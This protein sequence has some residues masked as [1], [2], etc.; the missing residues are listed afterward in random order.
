MDDTKKTKA[1]LID[2]LNQLR[3]QIADLQSPDNELHP[4]PPLADHADQYFRV[5]LENMRLIG[6]MLDADGRVTFCN[7]CL[8]ELTGWSSEE[9]LGHDWF[10][11]FLPE[12]VRPHVQQVFADALNGGQM[13]TYGENEIITR[14]GDRRLI[15]WHNTIL[16][17]PQGQCI[18]VTSIGEDITE[19]RQARVALLESEATARALLN[20]P[21]DSVLL[22][23]QEGIILDLNQTAADRLGK[24]VADLIGANLYDQLPADVAERRRAESDAILASGQPCH[25]EDLHAGTWYDNILYPVADEQG[26][27]TRLAI[28]ARDIT[29]RKLANE[30][31]RSQATLLENVSDAIISTDMDFQITSWNKG[32]EALFGWP[33]DQ[34]IGQSLLELTRPRSPLVKP[35][36]LLAS[37]MANGGWRGEI[38]QAHQDGHLLDIHANISLIRDDV[39]NPVAIVSVNH[40]IT[41]RKLL[42]ER[43]RSRA[44]EV[45]LLYEIGKQLAHTRDLQDIYHTVHDVIFGVMDCARLY[46]TTFSPADNLIRCVFACA[47]GQ[48]LDVSTFPVVALE[49]EGRGTQ[50]RVI[51]TGESLYLPD[52]QAETRDLRTAYHVDDEG[53]I[54]PQEDAPEDAR[55]VQSGL[56]VPLKFEGQVIGVLQVLS[57]ELDAFSGDNLR[58]LELL[59][60]QVT[61]VM[62]NATLFQQAQQEIAEREQ[63]QALL[64]QREVQIRA[65]YDG[66]PVP[67]YTWQRT[68]DQD[69]VLTAYNTAALA[70]TRGKVIDMMGQKASEVY[71]ERPTVIEDL[72]RCF[73]ERITIERETAYQYVTTGEDKFV[74]IKYGFV[75]PDMV[76]IHSDDITEQKSVEKAFHET[77][78]DLTEAQRIGHVG[79]WVHYLATG[80]IHWSHELFRIFGRE[81]KTLRP[82]EVYDWIHPEDRDQVRREIEHSY[83]TL[84]RVDT[85]FRI[86]RTDGEERILHYQGEVI[87]DS[88]GNARKTVGTVQDI[89]EQKQSEVALQQRAAQLSLINQ[90]SGEIA[91]V[92]DLNHVLNRAATLVQES[93]GY[94]HVGL[95]IYD[96]ERQVLLM[97]AKAGAYAARFPDNHQLKLGEGMVGWV[98]EQNQPLLTNDVRTEPRFYNPFPD[99]IIGSEFSLPIRAAQEIVGVLDVQSQDLHAFDDNDVLVLET[100]ADQIAIAIANAH[101]YQQ[102]QQEI[103]ERKQAEA[104]LR[105][106]EHRYRALFEGANDAIFILDL[107]A[108]HL[109]VNQH[110]ADLLGYE[111][112]EMIGLSFKDVVVPQEYDDAQAR[113]D[114]LLAGQPPP[115]YERILRKKNGVELPVE[116]NISLTHDRDG[117]PLFIQSIV[118]DITERKQIEEILYFVA[119]R[120]WAVVGETFFAALARYLTEKLAVDYVHIA[121]LIDPKAEIVQSVALCYRGEMMENIQYPLRHTPCENIVGKKLASYPERVQERFPDDKDLADLQVESYVGMPLWGSQGN[122]IGLIAVMHKTP[123]VNIPLI[124]SILQIVAVRAAH[125]MERAQ[126]EKQALELAVERERGQILTQFIRDASHEFRTPLSLINLNIHAIKRDIESPRHLERLAGVETIVQSITALVDDLMTMA[127]LDSSTIRDLRPVDMTQILADLIAVMRDFAT[128]NKQEI[129]QDFDANSRRYVEVNPEQINMAMKNILDNAIRFTPE[130]GTITVRTRRP[131]TNL[132]VEIEDTG[133]GMTEDVLPHIFERFYRVD[134]A[135]TTHGF[136]LGLPIAQKIVDL[137]KGTIEVESTPGTGSI[138]RII[139]PG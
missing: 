58:F 124:E 57:L 7:R 99:E 21:A 52:F 43:L 118:R 70:V 2:E 130:N 40:D 96:Q 26:R 56:L 39:G 123:L 136:G 110:A 24:S 73:T 65:Q 87:A 11:R 85:Q 112:N 5:V 120:S 105:E 108:V 9:V 15:G 95:F 109:A 62:V 97:R 27:A 17:N 49:A 23:D 80:K 116:V 126:A 106:S 134:E 67:T 125:E 93:F 137:H 30:Q 121:E 76:L 14:A 45:T 47:Q 127:R 19:S 36:Q 82:G 98:A 48:T 64:R 32:A 4:G 38:T 94:Q 53:A 113:R 46:I 6:V 104:A 131:D 138:F 115:M 37:F 68:D 63:A 71:H 16:C 114:A 128:L 13:A 84:R 72:H 8:L 139:L 18:G 132:I 42:E 66:I 78:A 51:R 31:I 103:S 12:D 29:E 20:A 100:L 22:I 89:T 59:A 117:K 25:Q 122:P 90:V 81:R 74:R 33:A 135:H 102:A 28:V 129:L 91:A 86:L 50:S 101:S 69:F 75:P 119:Q 10:D 92:L 61:A 1:Q 60:P 111:I 83:Q 34:V 79:N 88:E 133:L 41:E 3:Q 55:W 77:Q 35:D 107:D 44:N 54:T